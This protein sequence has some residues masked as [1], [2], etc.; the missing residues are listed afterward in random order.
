MF[1]TTQ[2]LKF[3]FIILGVTL[4]L[5]GDLGALDTFGAQEKVI[6]G[7][8]RRVDVEDHPDSFL[9]ELAR[10]SAAKISNIRL[11]KIDEDFYQVR[12]RTLAEQGVCSDE[13]FSDQLASASCSG[14][15]IGPD[16]LVTA[17][18]CISHESDCLTHK[19]VF[20]F[21]VSN[22]PHLNEYKISS[23]QVFRCTEIV[24]R[25]YQHRPYI[26][27]AVIR[28]DRP[29]E[30]REFLE[31]RRQGQPS[32]SVELA[33]LGHPS[34]LPL[35]ITDGGRIRRIEATTLLVSI[36]AFAG[37]SGSAVVDAQT[38]VVEGILVRG[39]EDYV[40][41]NVNNCRR[42]KRCRENGCRGEDV[43]RLPYG[44]RR[45]VQ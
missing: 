30:G 26:D 23:E 24:E 2:L 9:R 39:E 42:P 31:L 1:R 14:F 35:K 25:K 38:G 10:S 19:W 43:V 5:G 29:V 12:G 21:K 16:L 28:L 20:D 34:G 22:A 17:A 32:Q 41:D 18:H 27:Y 40:W 33:M 8:D 7:E 15:L 37:N 36:D 3:P 4:I 44:T 13:R 11:Q 45:L 6:Y